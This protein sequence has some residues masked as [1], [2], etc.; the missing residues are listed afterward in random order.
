MYDSVITGIGIVSVYASDY[1]ESF[2]FYH[3]LLELNDVVTMNQ[4]SCYFKINDKVGMYLIGGFEQPARAQKGVGTTFALQVTSVEQMFNKLRDTGV[5]LV[6]SEPMQMNDT[7]Y[8]LQCYDP[9]GN[10]IE[11]IGNK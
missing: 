10:V 7:D 3:E 5:Q 6:Q 1:A 8:W 9:S 11:F 4:H 2:R